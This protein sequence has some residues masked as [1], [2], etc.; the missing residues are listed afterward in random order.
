MS[1]ILSPWDFILHMGLDYELYPTCMEVFNEIYE[2]GA[3]RYKEIILTGDLGTGKSTLAVIIAL[4]ELHLRPLDPYPTY[5]VMP[6]SYLVK[7]LELL[8]RKEDLF[9]RNYSVTDYQYLGHWNGTSP[10]TVHLDWEANHDHLFQSSTASKVI[11][12][13]SDDILAKNAMLQG[14]VNDRVWKLPQTPDVYYKFMKSKKL[15]YG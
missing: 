2:E 13:A 11:I 15:T 14:Y 6:G 12:D 7:F 8:E 1:R 3:N 10:A 5:L 4:Y 9:S